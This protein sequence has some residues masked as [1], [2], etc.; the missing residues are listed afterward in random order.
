WGTAIWLLTGDWWFV[1]V[2]VLLIHLFPVGYS[3]S[4]RLRLRGRR[5]ERG[6]IGKESRVCRAAG[7]PKE[8][9]GQFPRVIIPPHRAFA[10]GDA[11]ARG[12]MVPAIRPM[13]NRVEQEALMLG[14]RGKIRFVKNRVGDSQ[15]C[16]PVACTAPFVAVQSQV[17]SQAEQ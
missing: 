8:E 15:S 14:L 17:V 2:L 4:D 7:F 10:I 5:R 9:Q 13:V 11:L 3:R 6:R 1:S 16:L 12:D